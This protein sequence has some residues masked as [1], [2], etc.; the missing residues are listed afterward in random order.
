MRTHDPRK[1]VYQEVP[2]L[3]MERSL[4]QPNWDHVKKGRWWQAKKF[5]L[6]KI[7]SNPWELLSEE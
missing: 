7:G 4:V 2:G 1:E 5:E 3:E 6:L